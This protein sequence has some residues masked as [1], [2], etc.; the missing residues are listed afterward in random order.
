MAKRKGFFAR[1]LQALREKA[2]LTQ[3]ALAEKAGITVVGYRQLEYDRRQP[4]YDSIL[5]LSRALG[6]SAG[7]FFEG[8]LAGLPP[9]PPRRRKWGK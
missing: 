5:R 4:S 6:V 1:Q 2:G 8:D 7:V 3:T 9:G